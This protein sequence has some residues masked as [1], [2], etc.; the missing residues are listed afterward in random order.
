MRSWAPSRPRASARAAKPPDRSPRVVSGPPYRVPVAHDPPDDGRPSRRTAAQVFARDTATDPDAPLVFL[1]RGGADALRDRARAGELVCPLA[2]CPAPLLTVRAGSRVRDHFAHRPDTDP[3]HGPETVAH[4]T[5][6]HLIGRAL[7]AAYPDGRV[8][9]DTEEVESGARPDVLLTLPDGRHVAYEIQLATLTPPEW[10]FR[11]ERY[12]ADGIRDVWLFAGPSHL[13]VPRG[14]NA[15]TVYVTDTM[16]EVLT[17]SHPALFLDPVT[18]QVGLASGPAV[19]SLLAGVPLLGSGKPRA[20]ID[21]IPVADARWSHGVVDVPG[22]RPLMGNAAELRTRRNDWAA[23]RSALEA[24]GALPPVIDEGHDPTETRPWMPPTGTW[25]P[26]RWSGRWPRYAPDE[27]RWLLLEVLLSTPGATVDPKVS[28][29]AALGADHGVPEWLVDD[30]FRRLG[31]AGYVWFAGHAGPAVGEG[32]LVLARSGQVP[33]LHARITHQLVVT[34]SGASLVRPG[35]GA[36]WDTDSPF[37]RRSVRSRT[38]RWAPARPCLPPGVVGQLAD[39]T[40]PL[41]SRL[42]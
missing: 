35:F 23:H 16:V 27:W 12:A 42:T 20:A 38:R 28:L 41:R 39:A 18:Q 22:L 37:Q 34:D 30:F 17:Q 5:G 33:P 7:R 21:W 36:V 2:G 4:H 15:D 19:A 40:T 24:A 6:K 13:R 26:V 25:Q 32:V 8:V 31:M 14:A 9:V 29:T 3:G 11:H 1:P 10:T